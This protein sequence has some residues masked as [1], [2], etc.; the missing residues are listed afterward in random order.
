MVSAAKQDLSPQN[1]CVSM[2]VSLLRSYQSSVRWG[3]D[4]IPID[5]ARKLIYGKH[6]LLNEALK[7]P[8]IQVLNGVLKTFCSFEVEVAG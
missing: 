7:H 2:K 1:V 5:I 3:K 6:L 8:G 4:L